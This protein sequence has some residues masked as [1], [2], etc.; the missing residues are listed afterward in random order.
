[1][2]IFYKYIDLGVI[3]S[4]YSIET[5]QKLELLQKVEHKYLQLK[6]FFF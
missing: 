3:L 4:I 5:V 2:N 1:M 6:A